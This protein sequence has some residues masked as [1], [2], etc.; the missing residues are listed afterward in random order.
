MSA[1]HLTSHPVVA[2]FTVDR[3]I[4]IIQQ[5]NYS[6]LPSVHCLACVT[7]LSRRSLTTYGGNS[8][9]V[10]LKRRN[11]YPRLYIILDISASFMVGKCFP[12]ARGAQTTHR[13]NI[14]DSAALEGAGR[15]SG[16]GCSGFMQ[17]PLLS[18]GYLKCREAPP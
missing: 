17:T 16:T 14:I 4:F 1:L 3:Q 18:G 6:V 11:V 12:V 5:K 7:Q 15:Q 13:P 8:A 10:G 9:G 2:V